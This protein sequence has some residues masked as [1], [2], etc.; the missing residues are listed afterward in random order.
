M[1]HWAAVF[2]TKGRNFGKCMSGLAG[3]GCVV[4]SKPSF[5]YELVTAQFTVQP[6]AGVVPVTVR[7]RRRDAERRA[8]LVNGQAREIAQLHKLPG[9]RIVL[10][11][12]GKGVVDDQKLIWWCRG[13]QINGIDVE[14][15]VLATALG[16]S[17]FAGAIDENAAHRLSSRGE[18]MAARVPFWSLL[19]RVWCLVPNEPQIGFVH[20]GSGL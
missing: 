17:F 5:G 18:E 2:L 1:R 20:Q 19:I 4:S 9:N 12:R 3:V 8:C 16:A 15:L 14:L 10:G 11:Q 6:G 13:G 7:R